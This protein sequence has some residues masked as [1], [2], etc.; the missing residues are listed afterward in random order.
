MYCFLSHYKGNI[1][2]LEKWNLPTHHTRSPFWSPLPPASLKVTIIPALMVITIF[3]S[4]FLLVF[5]FYLIFILCW[6]KWICNVMLVSGTQPSD[7]G[8][9]R[10]TSIL[11]QSL[12][13]DRLLQKVDQS[14][15]CCTVG[16][17]HLLYVY[18]YV[19]VN[20]KLLIFPLPHIF[21]LVTINL[22][23]NFLILLYG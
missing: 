22:G 23:N 16:P 13:P 17:C 5:V 7:S 15:L 21:P 3:I 20:L 1:H 8:L 6:S 14:S 2:Q 10:H 19:S 9:H 18:Y 4:S 12:S 11:R